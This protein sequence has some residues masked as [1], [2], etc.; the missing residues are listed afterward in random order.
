MCD[1]RQDEIERLVELRGDLR[2]RISPDTR[3]YYDTHR[4][5]VNA[6]WAEAAQEVERRIVEALGGVLAKDLH[7]YAAMVEQASV[8]STGDSA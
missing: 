1:I 8:H 5:R 2:R 6:V 3:E 7:E 4:S